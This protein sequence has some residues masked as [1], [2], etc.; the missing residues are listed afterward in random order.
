MKRPP[1]ALVTTALC[2]GGCAVIWISV[3]FIEGKVIKYF[4]MLLG[5]GIGYVG[6]Y[7]AQSAIFGI[8][9][10]YGKKPGDKHK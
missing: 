8:G 6:Y 1:S 5:L 3:F 9:F 4:F 7:L 2:W 10:Y